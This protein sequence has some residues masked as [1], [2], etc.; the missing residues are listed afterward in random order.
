MSLFIQHFLLNTW[1]DQ[2]EN[3]YNCHEADLSFGSGLPHKINN[4]DKACNTPLICGV[5]HITGMAGAWSFSSATTKNET[6]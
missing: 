1:V 2:L 5:F 3:V 6:P 4:F